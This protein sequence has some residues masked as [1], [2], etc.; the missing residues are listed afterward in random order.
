MCSC[1]EGHASLQAAERA[2]HENQSAAHVARQS[3][4]NEATLGSHKVNVPPPPPSHSFYTPIVID[5]VYQLQ[6]R[7]TSNIQ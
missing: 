3:S 4:Q 2:T 6:N 1:L 5:K 7:S